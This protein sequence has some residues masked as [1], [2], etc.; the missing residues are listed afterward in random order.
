MK[1]L[2][3]LTLVCFLFVFFAFVF[4]VHADMGPKPSL[5]I[6]VKN[7]PDE[8]Y[9]LDLLI[10]NRGTYDNLGDDRASLD[11]SML[12]LLKSK[13]F[14]GWFPA[15]VDGTTTPLWAKLTGTADGETRIHHFNY[16]GVP[17]IFKIIVVTKS[18]AVKVSETIHTYLFQTT[19]TYDMQAQKLIMPN[20][21]Y[22]YLLQFFSTF[23]PTLLIEGLVLFLYRL[24]T[25]KNLITI[26][27]VNFVT[28]LFMTA[29]VG[30]YL[31]KYGMFSA[32]IV[33]LLIEPVIL[34][35]EALIYRV[36]L[37]HGSKMRY[38]AYAIVANFFSWFAGMMMILMS[39]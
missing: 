38:V 29:I 11:P 27:I 15:L 21:A 37:E 8:P 9:Y 14:D 3:F 24:W 12:G 19:I 31:F 2:R 35:A 25:R 17:T 7:A 32:L 39:K 22:A 20:V 6:I 34:I 26:L 23:I 1:P 28:Q 16:M 4:P 5:T 30:S 13:E 33:L 18:G 10:Q 36:K